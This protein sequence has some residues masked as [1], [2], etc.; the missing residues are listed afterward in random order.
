MQFVKHPQHSRWLGAPPAWDH[1]KVECLSLSIKD[2]EVGGYKA[3]CSRWEPTPMEALSLALGASQIELAVLSSAHPPVSML[4][5]PVAGWT[6]D[7]SKMRA[8]YAFVLTALM[9]H[10]KANGIDLKALL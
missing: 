8:A 9:A 2:G 5:M 10:A 7:K 1:A 6:H 3:M 4:D